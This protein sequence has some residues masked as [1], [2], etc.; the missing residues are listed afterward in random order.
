MTILLNPTL[1][2]TEENKK[3]VQ[4][5]VTHGFDETDLSAHPTNRIAAVLVLLYQDPEEDNTLRVLLTTRAKHLRT[6]AGQTAL[7]GGRMDEADGRDPVTAA[8]REANEETCL[9]L[10]P[11]RDIHVLC[12]LEPHLSL[13]T[14]LVIP[15]IA[16]LTHPNPQLFIEQTLK[17]SPNEVSRIFSHPLR[18]LLD[19]GRYLGKDMERL[20]ERGSEDWIYDTELHH[21]TDSPHGPLHL[22]RNHRFRSTGSPIKGLT[23]DILIKTASIAYSQTPSYERCVLGFFGSRR[24]ALE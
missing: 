16:L 8:F 4:R 18:A 2:L 6:H 24:R 19:P 11:H 15:V 17:P 1:G 21:T 9:P 14:L 12:T 23:S 13:H 10:P 22:Y 7:P 5:L 20:A 3:R